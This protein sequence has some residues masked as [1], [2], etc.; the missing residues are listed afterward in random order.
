MSQDENEEDIDF[1]MGGEDCDENRDVNTWEE[2]GLF[3]D[4]HDSDMDMEREEEEEEQDKENEADDEG[5]DTADEDDDEDD[6]D[7]DDVARRTDQDEEEEEFAEDM[8][9]SRISRSIIEP[10]R[11]YEIQCILLDKLF[12]NIPAKFNKVNGSKVDLGLAMDVLDHMESFHMSQ[13]E[14]DAFITFMKGVLEKVT[15][16]GDHDDEDTEEKTFGLPSC[17]KNVSS[18][19]LR[20]NRKITSFR[21]M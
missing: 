4:G 9:T 16:Q 14:G 13:V 10:N 19:F 3:P 5:V 8:S 11:M 17:F 1:D 21:K 2:M 18:S 12:Y 7:V 20:K 15:L 6:G